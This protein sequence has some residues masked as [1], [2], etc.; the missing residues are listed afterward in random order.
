MNFNLKYSEVFK[1]LLPIPAMAVLWWRHLVHAH[2]VKA[3]WLFPLV[4][5]R[6][7]ST[8]HPERCVD[9]FHN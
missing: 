9:V 3:G 2:G 1:F 6:A 7:S 5:K 4:Y 8:C